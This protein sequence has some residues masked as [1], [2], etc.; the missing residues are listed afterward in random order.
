MTNMGHVLHFFFFYTK[1]HQSTLNG[2]VSNVDL[3]DKVVRVSGFSL[4]Q[5][6]Q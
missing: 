1:L 4:W 2:F 5:R 3:S 6:R